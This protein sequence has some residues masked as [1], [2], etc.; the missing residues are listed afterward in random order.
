MNYYIADLHFGHDNILLY[1]NRPF[2]SIDEMDAK[3]VQNWNSVVSDDDT[4]YHLGD[5]SWRKYESWVDVIRQLNGKIFFV[6]GNHDRENY[7][8]QLLN[9][10]RVKDRIVGWENY[11]EVS[12]AGRMV[13]LSHYY[14]TSHNGMFRGSK[15][16]YGH[17][18]CTFDYKVCLKMQETIQALYRLKPTA[19]NVGAM[20]PYMSYT[21]RTLDEIEAGYDALNKQRLVW[22]R[23]QGVQYTDVKLLDLIKEELPDEQNES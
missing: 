6:K 21:P 14:M 17:V 19:Y 7:L 3:L 16:L 12:D 18:H 1:D 2:S 20:I 9:D 11:K 23:L 13:V 10:K 22:T 15:H 4:V 8:N 5:F